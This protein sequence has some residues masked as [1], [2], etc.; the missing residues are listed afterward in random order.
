MLLSQIPAAS[1]VQDEINLLETSGRT[2][3]MY[4]PSHRDNCDIK[5]PFQEVSEL[6]RFAVSVL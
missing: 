3:K 2:L 4:G 6:P 1:T 5:T